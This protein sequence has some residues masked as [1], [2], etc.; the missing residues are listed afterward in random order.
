[1]SQSIYGIPFIK[2]RKALVQLYLP[3][4]YPSRF[5][6]KL[7]ELFLLGG[8]KL[9][10]DVKE[11][12]DL[13]SGFDWAR[14]YLRGLSPQKTEPGKQ[15][16]QAAQLYT[17]ALQTAGWDGLLERLVAWLSF[18]YPSGKIPEAQTVTYQPKSQ[19]ALLDRFLVY[20]QTFQSFEKKSWQDL[21]LA[22]QLGA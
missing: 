8:F 11:L 22:T 6:H 15:L 2:G 21:A 10:G 1:M 17:L 16:E 14:A 13:L 12:F 9:P 3:A 20:S 18:S 5:Q 7:D 19:K 4:D